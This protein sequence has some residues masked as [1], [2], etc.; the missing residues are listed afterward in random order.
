MKAGDVVTFSR[1]VVISE[2]KKP[3]LIDRLTMIL[4]NWRLVTITCI[5]LYTAKIA[6]EQLAMAVR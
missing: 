1:I 6:A 3:G 5:F 4:T 2:N